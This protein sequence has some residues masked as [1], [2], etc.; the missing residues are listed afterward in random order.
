MNIELASS[1]VL[2]LLDKNQQNFLLKKYESKKDEWTG[3]V[4]IKERISSQTKN[5]RI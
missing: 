3:N 5:K 4:R 1:L 2:K